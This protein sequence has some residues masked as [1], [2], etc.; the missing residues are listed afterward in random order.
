MKAPTERW[1][2]DT[3]QAARTIDELVLAAS[4]VI[5]ALEAELLVLASNAEAEV[6]HRQ[7]LERRV[8][9]LQFELSKRSA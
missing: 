3:I 5:E 9:Q 2:I 7:A 1:Y 4:D 8:R 6:A